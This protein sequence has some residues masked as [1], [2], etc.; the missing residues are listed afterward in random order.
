MAAHDIRQD[1]PY[2][3]GLVLGLT[4]AEI[5]ILLIF[6]LLMALASAIAS[7]DRKIAGFDGVYSPELVE[8]IRTSYPVSQ[9]PDE[10]FKELVRA[11]DSDIEWR[12]KRPTGVDEDLLADAALGRLVREAAEK[13]SAPDARSFLAGII[14][15]DGERKKTEWP[16][17]FNLS[18]ERGY[19]F[20]TGKAT[21][22]PDVRARLEQDVIPRLSKLVAEY[23]VDV[24][25]VIGHTD[26]VPMPGASNLDYLLIDAS[27]GR[28]KVSRLRPADNS[29]LA[30]ARAVSV[31]NL[32]RRAPEL[33]G[34]TILPFSGAQMIVPVDVLSDGSSKNSDQARRR[35]EIRLR[36]KS[37]QLAGS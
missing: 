4:L 32:F 37:E 1:K 33:R 3:R 18:E 14:E 28:E 16:P 12:D 30:M 17:F 26:E 11:I 13:S 35:I 20:D 5:M 34:L 10:Y 25:E 2:R 8:K 29:G 22:R 21:L 19:F 7:R 15:T 24:I 36:R 6:V 31:V 9:S 23:G 27:V